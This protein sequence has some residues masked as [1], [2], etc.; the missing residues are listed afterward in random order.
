MELSKLKR[1]IA[2][3][4]LLLVFVVLFLGFLAGQVFSGAAAYNDARAAHGLPAIGYW[5]YVGTGNFLQGVF[6]NWQAAILQLGS[7]VLFSVFLRERGAAHS[8]DPNKP[9]KKPGP[10]WSLSRSGVRASGK[11]RG[12]L[13]RNSLSIAFAI[14]FL[15]TFVL[16][17]LS[18]AAS[19]NEQRAL[20][21]RGPLSVPAYF[22]SSR[23]WFTTLQTWEAEY[24][25][26]ALYIFLTIFLRQEG[27][28]ESKRVEAK[29][30]DTGD[31]NK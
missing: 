24:M 18:G 14:L 29:D 17:L 13:Y 25:A 2:D 10:R 30:S 31:T 6:S 3:H 8:L 22:V 19:Y 21:H 11:E 23:F 9:H 12:W 7:L 5:R 27:S 28:P 26:I 16:H 1:M 4:G 15:A 20:S